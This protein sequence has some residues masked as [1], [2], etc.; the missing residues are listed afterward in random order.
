MVNNVNKMSSLAMLVTLFS[1][2]SGVH[3]TP[4]YLA[5]SDNPYNAMNIY[6]TAAT[7]DIGSGV[8]DL[9]SGDE[10]GIFD[11]TVCVGSGIVSSTIAT[12][13]ILEIKVSAQDSDW[14][15]GTGFTASNAISIHYWDNSE[16]IETFGV[17]ATYQQCSDDTNGGVDGCGSFSQLGSAYMQLNARSC[18]Y[19][20]KQTC[21]DGS[22]ETNKSD[23][24]TQGVPGCMTT[25]ACNYNASATV[26]NGSCVS[27]DGVCDTCESGVV[28]DNDLDN[29]GTCNAA[30]T[31]GCMESKACNY[32][33][34]AEFD[35]GSCLFACATEGGCAIAVP[36]YNCLGTLSVEQL[37][38]NLPEE[39]SITN[40]YPNP[41]NPITTINYGMQKNAAVK[42]LIYN[43]VGEEIASLVNTYQ[44]AGLHSVVWNADMHSGGM[45]LVKMIAGRHVYTKKLMLIK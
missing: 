15:A 3:F 7:L 6:V 44:T 9:V 5:N 20:S 43:I 19:S 40:I 28:V 16:E 10:I 39:F 31:A 32:D 21:W 27:V 23:C 45:Y 29:D 41:F 24:P 8:A 38:A 36:G 37:G 30:E 13:N 12:S 17:T 11:G 14:P 2:A 33:A 35:N 4:A 34:T 18:A 26:D 25:T 22:C 42:I 1:I